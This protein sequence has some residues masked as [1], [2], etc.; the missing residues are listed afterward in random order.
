MSTKTEIAGHLAEKSAC[1]RK[2][3]K[4]GREVHGA[5]YSAI[6]AEPQGNC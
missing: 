5:Y 2:N 4:C 3:C 1:K 6:P